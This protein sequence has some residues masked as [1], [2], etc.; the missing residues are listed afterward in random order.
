MNLINKLPLSYTDINYKT[1]IKILQSL[2]DEIPDGWYEDEYQSYILLMPISI[3]LD[4]PLIEIE[5]LPAAELMPMIERLSFLND[6]FKEVKTGLKL[7]TANELTYDEYVNYQKLRINQWDNMD[8]IL[9]I[10][11]KDKTPEQINRLDIQTV[12]SVFFCLNKSTLKSLR[13]LKIFLANQI[14]KQNLTRIWL[15]ITNL[16]KVQLFRK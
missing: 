11:I 5:R 15:M 1:Y 12:M 13:S 3:L 8:K 2:P 6:G 14:M 10:I 9:S 7:K 16:F 4:T